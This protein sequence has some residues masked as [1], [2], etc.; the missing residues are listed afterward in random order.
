MNAVKELNYNFG[1]VDTRRISRCPA[2]HLKPVDFAESGS[3]TFLCTGMTG[4]RVSAT[5]AQYFCPLL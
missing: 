2:D 4:I 1:S 3:D 5:V